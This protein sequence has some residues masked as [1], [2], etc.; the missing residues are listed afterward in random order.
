[1]KARREPTLRAKFISCVTTIM[2]MPSL[3]SWRITTS[4]SRRSSG[5]SAEVGSSNS[6]TLGDMASA[7]AMATRCCCPPDRRAG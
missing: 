3:A 5:S 7:R 1:M 6:M 2:V 4:T